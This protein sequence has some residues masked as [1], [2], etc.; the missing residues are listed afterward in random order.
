MAENVQHIKL[1]VVENRTVCAA[2][3]C[4][5]KPATVF[6]QIDIITI[7]YSITYFIELVNFKFV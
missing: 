7:Q 3:G 6:V 5:F 1:L 4:L 2:H